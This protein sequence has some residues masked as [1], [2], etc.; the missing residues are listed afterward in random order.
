MYGGA[1]EREGGR[2][3]GDIV[4]CRAENSVE[5]GLLETHRCCVDGVDYVVE[6]KNGCAL[7]EV[8]CE[9]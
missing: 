7:D 2:V 5:K 6:V 3:G 1:F 8:N 9:L 4:V